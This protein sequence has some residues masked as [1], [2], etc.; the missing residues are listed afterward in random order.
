[1]GAAGRKLSVV[2]RKAVA[3]ECGM[4]RYHPKFDRV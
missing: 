2:R 1:V 3:L 4:A